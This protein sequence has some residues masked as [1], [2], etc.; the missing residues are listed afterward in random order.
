VQCRCREDARKADIFYQG[1]LRPLPPA[2]R[3]SLPFELLPPAATAGR[4]REGPCFSDRDSRVKRNSARHRLGC[5]RRSRLAGERAV[6]P[7]SWDG[8]AGLT[9]STG[10]LCQR[11]SCGRHVRAA[12]RAACWHASQT[13]ARAR[14]RGGGAGGSAL[15]EPPVGHVWE[16]P[17]CSQ[18]DRAVRGLQ[19]RPQKAETERAATGRRCVEIFSPGTRMAQMTLRK[20]AGGSGLASR[21]G[22]RRS[23]RS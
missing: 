19:S 16:D 13:R 7:I 15:A 2:A 23:R 12:T 9:A 17:R 1:E 4:R 11:D 14:R 5:S 3:Q 10:R 6:A 20:C 22:K 8:G 21:V 18:R